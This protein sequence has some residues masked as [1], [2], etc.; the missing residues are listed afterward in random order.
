MMPTPPTNAHILAQQLLDAQIAYARERLTGPHALAT[1]TETMDSILAC[2]EHL[3]L[4]EVVSVDAIR[5]VVI[6]YAFELNL[7]GGMLELI[8][9]MARALHSQFSQN[10]PTLSQLMPDRSIA[11]WVDKIVE[12]KPLRQQLAARLIRSPACQ[13]ML[14]Q[15]LSLMLRRQLPY[16]VQ[17][18][19]DRVERQANT[20]N[21]R[22]ASV[23]NRLAQQEDLINDWLI[24]QLVQRIQHSSSTLLLLDDLE[25]TDLLNQLWQS[26]R[27]MKLD[28]LSEHLSPLDIEELFVLI[29]DDWRR[30]R[31]HDFIQSLILTG[32][33][34]FF[35]VYGDYT[36]IELI[37]EVGIT[38]QHM[39]GEII[40]F[41]PHA[42]AALDQTGDLNDLLR[43]QLEPFYRSANILQLLSDAL[44]ANRSAPS[45]D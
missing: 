8:G 37:D 2:G 4:N 3:C 18:L 42:I 9:A 17:Q 27:H 25:L 1:M 5:G 34:V 32:V 12:L 6:T 22:L 39:I 7:G 23:F 38:R 11:Q 29:Y 31:Q 15:V 26:I 33:D 24:D 10:S 21:S 45:H 16:W 43:L 40:R 30:L 35:E 41:A 28:C 14:S 36:L 20:R 13:H 44:D 19:H